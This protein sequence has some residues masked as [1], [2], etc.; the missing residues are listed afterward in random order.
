MCQTLNC[1]SRR[2]AWGFSHSP[3][4]ETIFGWPV[5]VFLS[6][7]LLLWVLGRYLCS[8]RSAQVRDPPVLIHESLVDTVPRA[9]GRALRAAGPARRHRLGPSR[10]LR[11]G[12][13]DPSRPISRPSPRAATAG[14]HPSESTDTS[15]YSKGLPPAHPTLQGLPPPAPHRATWLRVPLSRNLTSGRPG[16]PSCLGS[17]HR[18]FAQVNSPTVDATGKPQQALPTAAGPSG[19]QGPSFLHEQHRTEVTNCG[20]SLQQAGK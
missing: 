17:A 5:G 8:R 10:P 2:E 6:R 4:P 20:D 19:A 3:T 13:R 12:A 1:Q 7:I 15:V 16:S 18:E 14:F 11:T 9:R